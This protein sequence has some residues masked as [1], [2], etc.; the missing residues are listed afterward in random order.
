V[1]G[2][3]GDGPS[4]VRDH[5]SRFREFARVLRPGGGLFVFSTEHPFFSYRYFGLESYF[6]TQQFSCDWT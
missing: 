4:L 1:K 6:E 5:D 2:C 3:P